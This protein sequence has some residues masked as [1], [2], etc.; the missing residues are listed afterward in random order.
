[1][2][3]ATVTVHWQDGKTADGRLIANYSFTII[4]HYEL[5]TTVNNQLCRQLEVERVVAASE[6]NWNFNFPSVSVGV[7][8]IGQ[9]DW[10]HDIYN[11]RSDLR[12]S[13]NAAVLSR[14]STCVPVSIGDTSKSLLR[15]H[16]GAYGRLGLSGLYSAATK[17]MHCLQDANGVA[18]ICHLLYKLFHFPFYTDVLSWDACWC[19]LVK[20]VNKEKKK[21]TLRC[22]T[23]MRC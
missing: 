9:A 6:C 12:N 18:L 22:C 13:Q 7:S 8:S 15:L 1:M 23:A 21:K 4:I 19:R 20:D 2:T 3:S 17:M 16:T 11:S 10:F 14:R 5:A